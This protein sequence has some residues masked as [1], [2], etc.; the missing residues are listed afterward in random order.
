VEKINTAEKIALSWVRSIE[1][2]E[3]HKDKVHIIRYE[4]LVLEPGPVLKAL[5]DWLGVDPAG[6]PKGLAHPASFGKYKTGLT[7]EELETVMELAGPTMARLGYT[8]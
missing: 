5:G 7:G 6:F 2:M 4:D 8:D 1:L 3:R